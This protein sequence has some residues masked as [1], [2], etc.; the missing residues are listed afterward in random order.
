MK[1]VFY[2]WKIYIGKYIYQAS[3]KISQQFQINQT[4]HWWK[5]KVIIT[6]AGKTSSK[7]RFITGNN[8]FAIKICSES[9]YEFSNFWYKH[10]LF[11]LQKDLIYVHV[12]FSH[13][14]SGIS[15]DS[16]FRA[17]HWNT[18]PGVNSVDISSELRS[19]SAFRLCRKL[20]DLWFFSHL[21]IQL[22][23]KH[24]LCYINYLR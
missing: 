5:I 19:N 17:G 7:L 21:W 14:L 11:C 16:F 20:R 4:G 10:E 12:Y 15:F 8:L 1:Y 13:N 22:V 23:L 6:A 24:K 18:V 3:Y 2:C 9:Q